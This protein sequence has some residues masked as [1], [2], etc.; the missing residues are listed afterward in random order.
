MTS[1]EARLLRYMQTIE[2]QSDNGWVDMNVLR[3]NEET[4]EVEGWYWETFD[5]RGLDNQRPGSYPLE[6]LRMP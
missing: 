5:N 1:G 4:D 6:K 2:Y 3:Y